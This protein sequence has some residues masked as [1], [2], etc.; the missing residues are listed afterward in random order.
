M[1]QTRTRAL[2]LVLLTI[3]ASSTVSAQGQ[4]TPEQA[5]A[6]LEVGAAFL[7]SGDTELATKTFAGVV[8]ADPANWQARS[9]LTL[10]YLAVRA[11]DK[12]DVELN[13]LRTQQT[14][15]AT[16][17]ALERQVAAVRQTIQMRDD[18]ARLLDAG[19]WQEALTSIEAGALADSRKQLLRGYVAALRGEFAEAR[20][21]TRDPQYAGVNASIAKREQE[22]QAARERA[23][24][25]FNVLGYRYCGTMPGEMRRCVGQAPLSST[26]QAAWDEVR[27]G[28]GKVSAA[29]MKEKTGSF[30][31]GSAPD[32]TQAN[33][34]AIWPRIETALKLLTEFARL[35]PLHP[36]ALRVT[37]ISSLY[38]GSQ[39]GVREAAERSLNA[40]GSWAISTRRCHGRQ[41]HSCS[42]GDEKVERLPKE[43]LVV[44]DARERMV[45]YYDVDPK[46]WLT[47]FAP[48]PAAKVFEIPFDQ[49][50]QIRS[51]PEVKP[52]YGFPR[53]HSE[54]LLFG[55]GPKYE[56]SMLPDFTLLMKFDSLVPN[57]VQAVQDLV[58][59]MGQLLPG[60]KVDFEPILPKAGGGF[61]GAMGMAAVAIGTVGNDAGLVQNSQLLL[62]Q[63][64]QQEAATAAVR[65]SLSELK[66]QDGES[67]VDLA[68]EDEGLKRDLDALLTTVLQ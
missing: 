1:V 59:A 32:Y 16:M 28:G 65:Q 11:L 47:D 21:L 66:T 61:A 58:N 45:R 17:A 39:N 64:R 5:K 7:K 53:T 33:G 48:A 12:V 41:D 68:L 38:S 4:L 15:A 34:Q 6:R 3:S 37:N 22:F 30:M 52:N 36:D 56:I 18:L 2:V 57:A 23:L 63:Q 46:G 25:A 50:S 26:Q 44:V 8:D 10:A 14:P 13:R 31:S 43:G 24:V 27:A 42:V 35:A 67:L 55:F 29:F 9:L 60:A 19:K 62:N 54:A 20:R 40:T 51:R 49:I